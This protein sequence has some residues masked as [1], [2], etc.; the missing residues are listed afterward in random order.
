MLQLL[1]QRLKFWKDKHSLELPGERCR[2]VGWV[3]VLQAGGSR[4]RFQMWSLDVSIVL[5]L[6]AALWSWSRLSLQQKWVS[7]IFL[8][9]KG[10]RRVK[11]TPSPRHL[12]DDC[13]ENVGASTSHNS[14]GLHGLLQGQLYLSSLYI[15][16]VSAAMC[17]VCNKWENTFK[18]FMF[19][20]VIVWIYQLT[21]LVRKH[22][23]LYLKFENVEALTHG[24]RT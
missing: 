19:I 18:I 6:L 10:G 12:W 8:G 22:K 5:I 20:N 24:T 16:H 13:L 11:L 21:A 2:V 17:F 23:H 3:T 4:V 9:V 1:Q 15:C 7:R 14:M